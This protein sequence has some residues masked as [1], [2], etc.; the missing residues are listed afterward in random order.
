MKHTPGPW[1]VGSKYPTDI[2]AD[3]AGHA[4]AQTCN[5]Q[6]DG[7]CEANAR[8]I[9]AAP[10]LLLACQNLMMALDDSDMS[11]DFVYARSAIKKAIL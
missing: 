10:E 3:R 7:E 11:P 2:Y 6:V 5:P 1:K 4:I 9:A 8:L